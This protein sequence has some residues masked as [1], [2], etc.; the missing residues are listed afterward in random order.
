M[1]EKPAHWPGDVEPL[2]LEEFEKLGRD[3][4][5]RLFWDGKHLVTRNQYIFTWPQKILAFLA[6]LASIATVA[7]GVNNASVFMCAR[8]I[9]WLGCPALPV[10]ANATSPPGQQGR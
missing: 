1:N 6:A 3:P 10:A 8:G 5:N 2:V 7:T 4:E 9:A